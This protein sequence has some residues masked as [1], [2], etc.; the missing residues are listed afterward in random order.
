MVVMDL[1]MPDKDGVQACQEVLELLTDTRV[2][3]L[4][5][6]GDGDEVMRAVAA[7]P[8]GFVWKLTE[9]SELVDAVLKVAAGSLIVL[10]GA[11]IRAFRLLGDSASLRPALGRVTKRAQKVLTWFAAGNRMLK[12][13]RSWGQQVT[14]HNAIYRVQNKLGVISC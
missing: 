10:E 13:T 4:T 8:A 2:L 12:C 9:D 3:A 6:S 5:A 11:V 7:G 1:F 14:V